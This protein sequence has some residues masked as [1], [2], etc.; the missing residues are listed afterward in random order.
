MKLSLALERRK[1][2]RTPF[3]PLPSPQRE[4]MEIHVHRG[5]M[6]CPLPGLRTE[7]QCLCSCLF[8]RLGSCPS[9]GPQGLLLMREFFQMTG[10]PSFVFEPRKVIWKAG[11]S[12]LLYSHCF[13][14]AGI[15]PEMV[16]RE[17]IFCKVMLLTE[18]CK[19]RE[20]NPMT[21]SFGAGNEKEEVQLVYKH[22][23][24]SFSS[25]ACCRCQFPKYLSV[26]TNQE[27]VDKCYY[28]NPRHWESATGHCLNLNN[29][30]SSLGY[31]HIVNYM[32]QTVK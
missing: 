26:C 13:I 20:D 11:V 1:A 7:P 3:H 9:P 31:M 4:L 22:K 23:A 29:S 16:Y 5:A 19:R 15:G 18:G 30:R 25:V 24:T 27:V 17:F 8:R 21:L 28:S 2:Y 10:S 6:G 12:P 14:K 32:C